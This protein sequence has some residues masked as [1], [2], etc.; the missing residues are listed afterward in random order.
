M[1]KR[2]YKPSVLVPRVQL[3]FGQSWY[4]R[5]DQVAEPCWTLEWD[6]WCSRIFSTA[7]FVGAWRDISYE[8]LWIVQAAGHV[9]PHSHKGPRC[10]TLHK[11]KKM[12]EIDCF[13]KPCVSVLR[14]YKLLMILCLRFSLDF[15]WS[16][17]CS[18]RLF[19]LSFKYLHSILRIHGDSLSI[20]QVRAWNFGIL[21]SILWC[22]GPEMMG[23]RIKRTDVVWWML[24][25]VDV[26]L[27]NIWRE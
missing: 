3:P 25:I 6:Q 8:V 24:M 2:S 16:M 5:L 12:Q 7:P 26:D 19:M 15:C 1:E 23:S 10:G 20:Q 22:W 9:Y 13:L 21:W 14:G 4:D 27:D 17:W 18:I 11:C